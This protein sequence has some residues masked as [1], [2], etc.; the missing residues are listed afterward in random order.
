MPVSAP[1]DY[2]NAF[3]LQGGSVLITGATGGIGA[4][5]AKVL[6]S[7]GAF[8]FLHYNQSEQKAKS[9]LKE[10]R[11]QGGDGVGIQADLANERSISDMFSTMRASTRTPNMLVN[12]AARQDI[13][14]FES[15]RFDQ[16]R[17]VMTVNQDAV[18]LLI[19]HFC[20]IKPT[21]SKELA[22]VNIAS[23]EGLDPAH[24]HSHYSVSKASLMMLTRA[25]ASEMSGKNIRVNTVSPGLIDRSGLK[26]DW[27]EGYS[28]WTRKCPL[29]SVGQAEDVANAILFLLSPAAKW[30]NGVNLMVD[31]GMSTRDRW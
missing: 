3:S 16:W 17:E 2:S 4:V 18:F 19:R 7:A 22:I 5:T 30:V 26:D 8:V 9:L 11:D 15:M 12:M 1:A 23:I 28:R 27:S 31:G 24:G 25:V 21:P 10:I 6:A 13:Q 29:E 14:D 20:N